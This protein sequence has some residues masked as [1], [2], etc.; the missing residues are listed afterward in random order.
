MNRFQKL[1]SIL[2]YLPIPLII[3]A[4]ILLISIANPP[5]VARVENWYGE[6]DLRGHD[7]E[8][9]VAH[10]RGYV[11][12]APN[13]LLS[14]AEFEAWAN[15]PANETSFG[16][17][18]QYTAATSRIRIYVEDGKWY[19]FSRYSIDYSHRIFVNGEWLLD[20]GNPGE[21]SETDIPNTGRITFTAQGVDG[22]IEIV[23][24]SSNHVHRSGGGHLWWFVGTGTMLSDWA[25]AE[26]YQTAII[27][28]SFMVLALLFL[29]LFFTHRRN[30][31]NLFFAIFCFVW[32]MRMGVVGGRI[33]TVIVPWLDWVCK[34]RIEYIAIPVSAA[35]TL[36]IA[37]IIFKN[38]MH[39]IVIKILYGISGAFVLLFL[40]LDTVVMRGWLDIAFGIYFAAIVWL[41]V[42]LTVR[43]W[44]NQKKLGQKIYSTEQIMFG[45]GLILFIVAAVIDFGYVTAFFYMPNFHMTG[46]AVLVFALCEAAAVFTATMKQQQQLEV[47][48]AALESLSRMKTEY[49]T[50]ISHETKT[51]LTVISVHI[52]QARTLYAK[53]GNENKTISDSLQLAQKEIMRVARMTENALWL[54]SMQ[55][56]STEILPIDTE[57][58][59]TNSAEAFR[60]LAEKRKNEFIIDVPEE[61]PQIMG[62]TDHLIQVITNLLTNAIA[63]T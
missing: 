4:A 40:F 24:Q 18:S 27:L 16:W 34:F 12:Y 26:Q 58:L 54:A 11:E 56:N 21:T 45:V 39:E 35:L 55:N 63:H 31:A 9:Y 30:Y 22:V 13:V 37:N 19:T 14:P 20:I 5:P 62:N 51:P 57:E 44:T 53:S 43:H 25:R 1:K 59:L 29:V 10:L 46:V 33:F 50:N 61:L 38:A 3:L 52:Q 17:A 7:F 6:P 47:E 41:I 36:A 49:M 28:G 42:C 32:F 60:S 15:D 8:N 48:N 2:P 23:Q